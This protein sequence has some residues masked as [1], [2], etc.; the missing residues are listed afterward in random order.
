MIKTKIEWVKNPDG[1]QGTT[2]NCF[3]GCSNRCSYCTARKIAR[4]FGRYIGQKRKYNNEVVERMQNFFPVFLPD[5]LEVIKKMKKPTTFF[6]SEMGDPFF[7]WYHYSTKEVELVFNLIA[8]YLQHTFLLLTKHIML[9]IYCG[10]L[11]YQI[12]LMF[13]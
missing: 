7:N 6:I 9:L 5:Q 13:G 12:Y 8:Q 4:R 11:K 1:T 2:L 3:W 10:I